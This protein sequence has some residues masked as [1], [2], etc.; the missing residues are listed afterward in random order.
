MRLKKTN[1]QN[2]LNLRG[3][4]NKSVLIRMRLKKKRRPSE[5][6]PKA[7]NKLLLTIIPYVFEHNDHKELYCKVTYYILPLFT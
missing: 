2:P 7:C 5:S 4:K 6:L 1:P 3:Q